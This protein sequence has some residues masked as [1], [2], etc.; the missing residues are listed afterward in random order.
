MRLTFV[1][2]MLMLL[3]FSPTTATRGLTVDTGS[4]CPA[5]DGVIRNAIRLY[6]S[7]AR[8]RNDVGLTAVDPDHLRPLDDA[9][10]ATVCQ[11]LAAQ[12]QVSPNGAYAARWA[13]FEA[14]GFYFAG[15]V[16]VTSNGAY[17]PSPGVL[18]VLDHN[19]QVLRTVT[20]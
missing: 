3:N 11:F 4:S 8:V 5:V 1:S 20:L 12:A 19:L 16:G 7:D 15:V 6:V 17:V 14:D 18:L 10:D 9:Q 13:Y 2:T